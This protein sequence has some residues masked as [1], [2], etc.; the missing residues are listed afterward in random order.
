MNKTLGKLERVE[1]RDI[2]ATED[3]DFTP[4]LASEAHLE[5]LGDTI[6]IELELEA[7]EKEVG[8]FRADILCKSVDDDSWVLI[9]NQIERTDHKH[10]GQ[11]LTY[12]AGLQAVTI[13]WI[14]SKF[15]EEHRATIDWLNEIT[16]EKFRFFGLE[17][18]LWRINDSVAAPK[19][20]IIS[21]PNNWSKSIAQAAKRLSEQPTTETKELQYRYWQ[22]LLEYLKTSNSKLRLQK[23]L[24]QHWQTFAIGRSHFNIAALLNTRDNRIG[25]ELCITHPDYAK[26]FYNILAKD[27]ENIEKE[28]GAALDWR[29]LPEKTSSKII[30][31]KDT[32]PTK[33]SD[34]SSQHEWFKERLE[35]FDRVF[36]KRVRSLDPEQWSPEE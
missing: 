30:Q 22:Q 14:A 26:N 21:K 32:D 20:N 17:V 18:E 31:F 36:R 33:E 8:P 27:K 6:G 28:I 16:D 19:F 35:T 15:T 5:L 12:A 25:V 3:R 9:E 7:Q 1:L 29:E 24:P 11:L 34:W 4:W 2:W 23:P 13:V 10:L